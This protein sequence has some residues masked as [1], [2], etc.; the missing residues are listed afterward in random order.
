MQKYILWILGILLFFQVNA[1][2][3]KES[4][5]DYL[6]FSNATKVVVTDNK[7]YC[8]TEGGLFYYDLQDNSINKFS[9]LT[10]LSDFGIKTIAYSNANKVLVVVY[11]NSNIDL[12]R[13]SGII[14]LPDI[15]RKQITGD[16][17]I[18]NISFVGNEALLSC[19]FGIVALNL[20]RNEVKDTYFIGEEGGSLQVNDVES[21]GQFLFAATNEGIL[22]ADIN[23]SNLL[24]Y[25]N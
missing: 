9:G 22:K 17:N 11:K 7:I 8:V 6:S 19:G 18:N 20:E 14:N 2:R 25:R 1:Q 12:V 5:K 23:S 4:W 15:K 21:D 24:D 10:G 16:K 3:A 13:E